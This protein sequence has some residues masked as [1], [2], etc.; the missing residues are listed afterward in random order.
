MRA[1]LA[2]PDIAG[3]LKPLSGADMFA[4]PSSSVLRGAL[5]LE[6]GFYGSE[7]YRALLAMEKSG[8]EIARVGD[9]AGVKWFGPFSRTYVDD[10][11]AGV[12]FLSSSEML[13]AKLEPRNFLSTALTPN[14]ERLLVEEGTILVSCSGT[15]GNVAI[16]TREFNGFAISQH[17]IRIDPREDIDRGPLYAFLLSELGQFLVTRNKSGSV[18]ESIYAADV[19]GLPLPLLPKALRRE[20]SDSIQRACELRVQANRSLDEAQAAMR[21]FG[22]FDSEGNSTLAVLELIYARHTD[23]HTSYEGRPRIR[24][25]ATFQ[26]Q[27]ANRAASQVRSTGRWAPLRELVTDI[28][29]TGPGSM[30]GVPKVDPAEGVPCVTGRDLRLARPRPSYFVTSRNPIVQAKMIPQQGTTLMMCAGTLGAT[31]YVKGNYEEW[32]VSL[33]VIR[34]VPDSAKLHPGYVYAFLSSPLGQSQVLRHKYGSVIPRIHSRQVAE[35]LIPIPTD[36]GDQI[37]WLV[38]EAFDQRYEA[39]RFESIAVELFMAAIEQGRVSTEQRWGR[40][41]L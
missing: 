28:P 3:L 9:R 30:P 18:I 33:D 25:E 10:P 39:V 15:I 24:L 1:E 17:A 41:Y 20:L 37:G 29:F 21:K 13:A 40:E 14:L 4:R 22:Q 7:G 36:R 19:A 2:Q 6:A 27:I 35:T 32:A 11:A 16:C 8:F 31:D 12:P 5:R 34:V 26:A 38:D 23:L